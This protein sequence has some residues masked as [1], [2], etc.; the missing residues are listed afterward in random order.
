MQFGR[1]GNPFRQVVRW[2][3]CMTLKG[4]AFQSQWPLIK[5]HLMAKLEL[6]EV[7]P[8][9]HAQ[10]QMTKRGIELS[11]IQDIV[12]FWSIDEMYE[13]YSY[14]YGDEIA[15][16]NPDPVFSITG[17]DARARKLTIAFALKKKC[18]EIRFNIVTA[19]FEEERRMNRH[20]SNLDN[21]SF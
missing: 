14:P 16:K 4:K 21:N 2:A 6:N 17:Q 5:H 13:P 1:E 20:Q 18:R 19:F 8:T 9:K 10:R 12:Q 3:T 15:Y 11:S 7:E